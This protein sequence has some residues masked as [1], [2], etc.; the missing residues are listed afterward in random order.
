MGSSSSIRLGEEVAA[1]GYPLTDVLSSSGNFTLGNVT[2]LAGLKDDS[3]YLQIS[4]PIQPGNSGGPLFD[5]NGNVVGV[6]TAKLNALQIM[7]A[8]E[9]DIAQ[10]VNFAIKGSVAAN[11]LDTNRVKFTTGAADDPMPSADLADQARA[12]SVFIQC[13]LSNAELKG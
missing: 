1:F 11:F 10:N 8:T 13:L 4:T 12:T 9:G 7:V 5:R 2:A 3:R 6:V